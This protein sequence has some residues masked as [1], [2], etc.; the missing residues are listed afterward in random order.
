MLRQLFSSLIRPNRQ[1]LDTAPSEVSFPIEDLHELKRRHERAPLDLHS[2]ILFVRRRLPD[3]NCWS[4]TMPACA[5][6]G[7][8]CRPGKS[9]RASRAQ[10]ILRA[11]FCTRWNW[12]APGW[13]VGCFRV[14]ALC[15]PGRGGFGARVRWDGVLPGRQ[16]RGIPETARRGLYPDEVRHR[17]TQRASIQRRRRRRFPRAGQR[18]FPRLPGVRFERG[19]IP[20]V[21]S[22]L[23]ETRWAFVHIDV[24]LNE[25][26]LACLEYFYPRLTSSA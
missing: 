11:I 13:N 14:L 24:D 8:R 10:R 3:A 25:P 5:R 12:L 2:R 20:D 1:A 4:Y 15:L 6:P 21:L 19:F 7:R 18:C 17:Y 22:R 9:S 23:P 16:L 26:T